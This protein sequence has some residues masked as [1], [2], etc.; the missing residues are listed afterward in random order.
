MSD[1]G[2]A[3]MK[4]LAIDASTKATGIAVFN[5]SELIHYECITSSSQ[6]LIKRIHVMVD[7]ID[8]LIDKFQIE[9]VVVE[10][11]IPDH[12]KN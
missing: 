5:D 11:V 12:T 4:L 7:T 8:T 2:G 3:H 10:E 1:E 9:Q 6:D